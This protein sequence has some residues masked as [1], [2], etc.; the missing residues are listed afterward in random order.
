[1]AGSGEAGRTGYGKSDSTAALVAAVVV[2]VGVM[3]VVVV[4]QEEEEEEGVSATSGVGT[5]GYWAEARGSS[6]I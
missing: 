4:V 1:M 6:R 3:V 5:V 2:A